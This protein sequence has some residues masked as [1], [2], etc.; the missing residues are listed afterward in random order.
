MNTTLKINPDKGSRLK[1]IEWGSIN[2]DLIFDRITLKLF[3]EYPNKY[4]PVKLYKDGTIKSFSDN[5]LEAMDFIN[6]YIEN[7]FTDKEIERD[8]SIMLKNIEI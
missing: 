7:D 1:A 4:L 3:I 8:L 5:R 6:G 2:D